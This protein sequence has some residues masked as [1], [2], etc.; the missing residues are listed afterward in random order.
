MEPSQEIPDRLS[1]DRPGKKGLAQG[2]SSTN[3]RESRAPSP[4][5]PILP[6]RHLIQ[7]SLPKVVSK[8]PDRQPFAPTTSPSTLLD[9][10]RL[11]IR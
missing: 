6:L 2:Q 1:R 10:L 8:P 4:S 3:G 7:A 5:A 11:P 9:I